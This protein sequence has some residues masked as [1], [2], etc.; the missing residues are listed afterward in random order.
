MFFAATLLFAGKNLLLVIF[1]L[2]VAQVFF[3]LGAFK[4]SSP[5]SFIGAQREIIQMASSEPAILLNAV[6]MYMVVGSFYVYRIVSYDKLL[7]LYLP[8]FLLS[9]IYILAIK[10]RKSPFDL[11]T[12]SHAHQEIV[13]GVTV[14]FS[15][16]TLAMIELGHWLEIILMLGFIF[17]F[18]GSNTILALSV[19]IFIYFLIVLVDNTFA[20]LK[21]QIILASSWLVT[22][23]MGATNIVAL[24]FLPR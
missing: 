23:V 4:T 11:S 19:A 15:G 14:D 17:L 10:F 5:Y 6:G 12:S 7:A 16:K 24:H 21:W 1:A 20:R 8:G 13:K 9:F 22:F 3:I 18:F 2:T